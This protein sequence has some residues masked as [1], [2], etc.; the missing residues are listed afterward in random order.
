[1]SEILHVIKSKKGMAHRLVHIGIHTNDLKNLKT[2][3]TLKQKYSKVKNAVVNNRI[4]SHVLDSSFSFALYNYG[5][6][7]FNER[8]IGPFSY[9]D[10]HLMRNRLYT[11]Y[12]TKINNPYVVLGNLSRKK[13]SNRGGINVW[14]SYNP[15]KHFWAKGN[16]PVKNKIEKDIKWGIPGGLY[17]KTVNTFVAT[18][19]DYT[20]LLDLYNAICKANLNPNNRV[21]PLV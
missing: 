8:L 4:N 10:A 21:G 9:N 5:P 3:A 6:N 13:T 1:M 17:Q 15:S 19:S 14:G 18:Y 11:L 20:N 2:N 7:E 12:E 16:Y